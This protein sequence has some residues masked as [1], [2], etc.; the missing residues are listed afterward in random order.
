MK[1][2]LLARL[3]FIFFISALAL[4]AGCQEDDRGTH[5]STLR[6]SELAS[7]RLDMATGGLLETLGQE[8]PA[9]TAAEETKPPKA[10]SW[11]APQTREDGS[12]LKPGQIAGFRI[13]YRLRHED[14]FNVI[15]I[16]NPERTSQPLTSL[17]PG[18]YEFAI[19]TIDAQGLE[20]RRSPAVMVDLI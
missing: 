7:S 14:R 20:S 1:I 16:N 18:A 15:P 10:L 17:P 5:T 8:K 12:A 6:A 19:T 11:S 13:Y 3:P 9:N 4:L 2:T